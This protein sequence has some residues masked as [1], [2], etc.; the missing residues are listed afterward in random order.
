MWQRRPFL[1]VL[2]FVSLC[3]DAPWVQTLNPGS[4]NKFQAGKMPRLQGEAGGRWESGVPH[5]SMPVVSS[6]TDAF[7]KS[8]LAL[9]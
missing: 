9:Y 1:S 6:T 3:H 2:P 5:R 4:S 7:L 8:F